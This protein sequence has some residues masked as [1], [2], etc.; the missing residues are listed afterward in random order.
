MY[1][2]QADI[3]IHDTG[4]NFASLEFRQNASPKNQRMSQSLIL[5]LM[6]SLQNRCKLFIR[7]ITQAHVQSKSNIYRVILAKP[8]KVILSTLLP[9]A[10]MKRIKP[11]YG[12]SE[13]RV[14]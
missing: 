14:H 12:I 8:I 6:P 1:I 4:K 13:A 10:I 7:D 9:N 3:N 11:L 2:G 5:T